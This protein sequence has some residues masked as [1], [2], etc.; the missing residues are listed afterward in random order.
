MLSCSQAFSGVPQG[1]LLFSFQ[2]CYNCGTKSHLWVEED[3][4]AQEALIAHVDVEGGPADGTDPTVLFDPLPRVRVVLVELLHDVRT[5]V[6]V[7]LL[8]KGGG[9]K[10]EWRGK[11]GA[12]KEIP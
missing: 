7:A 6:T 2:F 4:R 12:A 1:S 10:E 3:L 8:Y 11:G 5:D 9:V